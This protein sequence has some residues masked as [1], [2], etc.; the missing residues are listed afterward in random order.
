MMAPDLLAVPAAAALNLA[1]CTVYAARTLDGKVRPNGVSWLLWSVAPLIAFAAEL[2]K[3]VGIADLTTLS[4]SLGP[5][6]VFVSAVAR[7]GTLQR[8]SR[9]E[10]ACGLISLWALVVW[11]YTRQPDA[12]VALS[13]AADA[14]AGFP[15]LVKAYRDPLSED[16]WVYFCV[17]VGSVLTLAT[18]TSWSFTST[19]FPG[20]LL[21]MCGT[22]AFM[23]CPYT[24]R[25][26]AAPAPWR[27][28][29]SPPLVSAL[30]MLGTLGVAVLVFAALPGYRSTEA[31]QTPSEVTP[32][33][34]P[35][36]G[37]PSGG[38]SPGK[39]A[40]GHRTPPVTRMAASLSLP[41]KP[42]P[43]S[44]TG[45]V[46]STPPVRA[47]RT[48]PPTRTSASPTPTLPAPTPAPTPT[49]PAPTPTS[50]HSPP[51]SSPSPTVPT[52]TPDLRSR[53]GTT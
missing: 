8:P 4:V 15:T 33:S 53:P 9:P 36:A 19:G 11:W 5:L 41:T 21:L 30:G 50:S 45:P 37:R 18:L 16:W 2:S 43:L 42:H 46:R 22:L 1:G 7:K 31:V 23:T 32:V 20:Y 14:L 35:A 3:G 51:T 13:I 52:K 38:Q 26:I 25:R 24:V 44:G 29:S 12:A 39:P 40:G 28:R 17:A 10:L 27:S 49:L 34:T 47:P 6:L 48:H